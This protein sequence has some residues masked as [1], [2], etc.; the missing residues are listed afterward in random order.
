M[1]YITQFEVDQQRENR[2]NAFA[3][4]ITD[5]ISDGFA[6]FEENRRRALDEK[7]QR[8]N[9]KLKFAEAGIAPTEEEAK[10]LDSTGYSEG[11][12]SKYADRAEKAKQRKAEEAEL[13]RRLKESQIYANEAAATERSKPFM[14]S[15]AGQEFIAKKNFEAELKGKDANSNQEKLEVPGYG[16]VRTEKEAMD[17][18]AAKADADD[19]SKLIDELKV[20]GN[21]VAVWDRDKIAK[22]NQLKTVLA[23]KLR[24]PL[25]GPGAMTEDEFQRLV[26]NIG[27]PSSVFSSESIE[28]GKLDQLKGILDQTVQSKFASAAKDGQQAPAPVQAKIQSM[29]DEQKAQRLMELRAKKQSMQ[30]MR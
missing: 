16:K 10:E 13:N 19:A 5:G 18:R 30:G 27:D 14:E 20:L 1:A 25:T 15:K 8:M 12:L 23:G 21:N 22:I 6:R 26:S 28:M 7:R 3:D 2:R 9:D 24:L 4:K 29:T 17:I 11:L